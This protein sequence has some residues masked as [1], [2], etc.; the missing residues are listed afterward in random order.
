MTKA[1]SHWAGVPRPGRVLLDGRYAR[2]EP[3]TI[4][5]HEADLFDSARQPGAE[6][7]F[8]YLWDEVPADSHDFRIW[9]ERA[10]GADD[11]LFFA[12]IDKATGRAEG[13][14]ALLRIDPVHGV[15]EIGHV[16]WGPA[17]A[18]TRVATEALYLFATYAFDTLGYR[19]F[20]WKCNDR[21]VPSK[22][23]ALRF[24]FTFEGIF[25]Q[26]MVVKGQNRDTAWF[27]IL[28]SDWPTLKTSYERWLAPDNFD[29][30][31][32]QLRKLEELRV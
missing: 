26:H 13:R 19:R 1:L 10:V 12:V 8:A 30:D 32:R 24:G 16:L 25:R 22:R 9:M 27:S 6:A 17:I 4:E 18:R 3:L 2:L 11:P 7:R 20:E 23:A 14:Q 31:G 15:I 5:R 21:N 29:G 28:D